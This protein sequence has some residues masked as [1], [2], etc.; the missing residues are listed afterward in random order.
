[1]DY[2]YNVFG[3][4]TG[5]EIKV[6]D[7]NSEF[8]GTPASELM[9]NAGKGLARFI[10][11]NIS[12]DKNI[13]FFCGKG[14]NAG[15]GFVAAR[16][17]SEKY[18]INLFLVGKKED[19]KSNI[20]RKNYE[21]LKNR[22][23]KLYDIDSLDKVNDLLSECDV[24]ID[25]MLGIGIKGKLRSPFDKIVEK[26]NKT[27]DKIVISVDIPTG[28]G[29]SL[30]IKPDFTVTFHD[31]KEN[32]N[33]K[34][35]GEIK[36]VDIKV[37]EKA[38]SYVGPGELSVYYPRS[39]KKSHK[40]DNGKV[41]IVGG[42]LYTGA[43]A[44]SALACLRAGVDLVYVAAPSQSANTISSYSPNLIVI[45]MES[46]NYLVTNDFEKISDL[47]K[48]VD[49]LVIGPGL[50]V[51]K[52]S[53]ELCFSVIK[54]TID[55]RKN[56]VIDAD[57]ISAI[58]KNQ[59]VIKDSNSVITPHVG[60]FKKLTGVDLSDSKREKRKEIVE[61]WASSLNTTIL[62]KSKV[63]IISN[64]INTKFN[65]IH[66]EAMTVGGT[67]DVLSGITAA[68]LSKN[69]CPFNSA[70]ISAFI[71]GYAGNLCFDKYSYGLLATDIIE[72]IPT[73]LKKYL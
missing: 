65:D 22:N 68:M 40:G 62:L 37:P 11:K 19:I 70:R 9:E 73:L 31:K 42:G 8:Y 28:I 56:L 49:T 1:M 14:N 67:G 63:D 24:I 53:K 33:K 5:K 58:S 15:D 16:Y 29:T 46:Q 44:L 21:K 59:E 36:I 18:K 61:K 13:L 47:L 64:G 4:T 55:F 35:S 50:G 3:M 38:K 52:E 32:M 25:G 17:L 43:P 2:W 6:I 69:I 7:I 48:K 26:I 60:E 39:S 45:P 27:S 72:E 51:K 30:S 34:N 20:S 23:I 71:N 41:L 12:D 66:N 57:A 54:K 10:K